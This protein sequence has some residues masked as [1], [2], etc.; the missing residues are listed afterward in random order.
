VFARLR[1]DRFHEDLVGI[2]RLRNKLLGIGFTDRNNSAVYRFDQ[3]YTENFG[4]A[5]ALDTV[6]FL[7]SAELAKFGAVGKMLSALNQLGSFAGVVMPTELTDVLNA[8]SG[9]TNIKLDSGVYEQ[10]KQE[11]I[12]T[13]DGADGWFGGIMRFVGDNGEQVLRAGFGLRM[14]GTAEWAGE[15]IGTNLSINESVQWNLDTG[16]ATRVDFT[17]EQQQGGGALIADTGA[18]FDILA[19]GAASLLGRDGMPTLRANALPLSTEYYQT[20]WGV[21][22]SEVPTAI[23][24]V[25]GSENGIV[26]SGDGGLFFNSDLGVGLDETGGEG[27]HA[28]VRAFTF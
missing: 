14:H 26:R 15:V 9:R 4:D 11:T 2:M 13:A 7:G 28:R 21:D 12:F 19:Q 20:A 22:P 23:G 24:Q 1:S 8:M 25:T 5:T 10:D 17:I 16:R 27:Q 18:L 3:T 6:S